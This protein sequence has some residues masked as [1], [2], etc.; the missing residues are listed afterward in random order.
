[1]WWL[2]VVAGASCV[3]RAMQAAPSHPQPPQQ[4]ERDGSPTGSHPRTSL[5]CASDFLS[6]S[7]R[8]LWTCEFAQYWWGSRL[9]GTAV[10][11]VYSLWKPGHIIRD[12]KETNLKPVNC[13]HIWRLVNVHV[14]AL[15]VKIKCAMEIWCRSYTSSKSP[16]GKKKP[17]ENPWEYEDKDNQV[18]TSKRLHFKIWDRTGKNSWTV[19][20][21]GQWE[22]CTQGAPD[23]LVC[24]PDVQI[25]T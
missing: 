7:Q 13:V 10:T 12:L 2:S 1:M 16:C 5:F 15:C 3:P 9:M 6:I 4:L 20:C 11:C 18:I 25:E 8:S 19:T 24:E 23:A 14:I 21:R 22:W 17:W